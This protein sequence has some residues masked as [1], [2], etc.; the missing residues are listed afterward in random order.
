MGPNRGEPVQVLVVDDNAFVRRVIVDRLRR[1][2]CEVREAT[3]GEQ[4][5]AVSQG[6][7]VQVVITDLNMP[8]L[9]G[10]ALLAA[11]RE[12]EAPPEVIL[13]TG[14]HA[15]DAAAAIQALRLGAHDYIA[16]DAMASEAVVLAVGRA[17]E[18]WRLRVENLRL[19]QELRRQSLTDGLTGVGNRRAFDEALLQEV[20]RARRSGDELSLVLLDLDHFKRVNDVHGHAAG[21]A[22]L[23]AFVGRARAVSRAC[24]RLFRFGGEEF[25]MLL[26][27]TG[28]EGALAKARGVLTA[29]A[30][31]PMQA[32]SMRVALTCSAGTASLQPS[33]G[34]SGSGLFRRADAALYAAKGAGR[35]RALAA[36]QAAGAVLPNDR[37]PSQGMPVED[38]C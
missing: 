27:G 28:A 9:N 17:Q 15:S 34:E 30:R 20:A 35:N 26:G 32:G 8:R 19:L 18:K 1:A 3:D 36:A 37:V 6:E 16:K 22:V 23:V 33:D 25:A 38:R 10:L 24:D 13:L 14:S 7:P 29:I 31:E 4:A 21:D 12:R 2:G 5:L 11:L